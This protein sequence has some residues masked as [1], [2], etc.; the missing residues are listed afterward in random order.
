[1]HNCKIRRGTNFRVDQVDGILGWIMLSLVANACEKSCAKSCSRPEFG[2]Q[3]C[4]TLC[5]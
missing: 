3:F 4:M 5:Q 2:T 1:M